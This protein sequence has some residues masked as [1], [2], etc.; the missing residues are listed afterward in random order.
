M[1]NLLIDLFA[2]Y[3]IHYSFRAYNFDQSA[4]WPNMVNVSYM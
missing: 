3:D 2:K 1:K 4:R